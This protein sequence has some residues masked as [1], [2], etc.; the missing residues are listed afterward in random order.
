MTTA[1]TPAAG[2]DHG[3]HRRSSV[4]ATAVEVGINTAHENDGGEL[5]PTSSLATTASSSP[6]Q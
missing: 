2:D 4:G 5:S 1:R 6:A 3:V